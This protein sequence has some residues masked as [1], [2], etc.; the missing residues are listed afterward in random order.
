MKQNR[1]REKSTRKLD[2]TRKERSNSR[3][4]SGYPHFYLAGASSFALKLSFCLVQ[5]VD[6]PVLAAASAGAAAAASG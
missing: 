3:Q 6:L 4:L 2:Q 5:P 1:E